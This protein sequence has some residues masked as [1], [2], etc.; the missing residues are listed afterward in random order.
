MV[1]SILRSARQ[2]QRCRCDRH[3]T[4][5][6]NKSYK[7]Q[8]SAGITA[9]S[10][11]ETSIRYPSQKVPFGRAFAEILAENDSLDNP[12][13]GDAIAGYQ[14][15]GRL[16]A[17]PKGNTL[18]VPLPDP[19]RRPLP[20]PPPLGWATQSLAKKVAQGAWRRTTET[21]SPAFSPIVSRCLTSTTQ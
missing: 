6:N 5:F 7:A 16:V 3:L 19:L 9:R 4:I 13:V 8:M 1:H 2:L 14:D 15:G 12:R 18:P 10:Y 20:R 21:R 11:S 17:P